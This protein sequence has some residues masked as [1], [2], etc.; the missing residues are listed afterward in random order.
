MSRI[1]DALQRAKDAQPKTLPPA[2]GP[3]LR[4]AEPSRRSG[5]GM[6]A[7]PFIAVI[8]IASL[9]LFFVW[10]SFRETSPP[11]IP[12]QAKT[13]FTANSETKPAPPPVAISTPT[14]APERPVPKSSG[15]ERPVAP[16]A[17]P[18]IVAEA[19]P[20]LKLQAIFFTPGRSSAII[21]GKT[22]RAGDAVAGFRVAAIG[23][24]SAT[25]VSASRTN[26]M[27]LGQ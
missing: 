14:A 6:A 27:T 2:P 8:L 10:Q 24:A 1:N 13:V 9:C 7:I 26:V 4:P 22:V 18:V 21:S 3:Q 17:A 11:P 20:S 16:V 19:P 23:P 25:L 15:P 5:F 12:A